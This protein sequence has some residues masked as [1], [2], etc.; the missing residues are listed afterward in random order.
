MKKIALLTDGWRKYVVYAWTEGIMRKIRNENLDMALFQFNSFGNWSRDRDNNAGEYNIFRLPELEEY[1][2]III[3]ANN[4]M[5]YEVLQNLLAIVKKSGKPAVSIG[6][7]FPDLYYVGID[8]R[9]P[10]EEIM[11]HLYNVHNCRRFVFAGGPGDNFENRQRAESYLDCLQKYHLTELNNP[12]LYGDYSFATGVRYM[13]DYIKNNKQLPDVFVCSNDNIATG[14][15]RT[16]E[17]NGYHVPGDFL[18]TGFDNLEKARNYLPQI[19]TVNMDRE[20]IGEQALNIL[21]DIWDGKEVPS[22]RYTDANVI[23]AESCGCPNSGMV[24]YRNYLKSMIDSSCAREVFD[25]EVAIL[26]REVLKETRMHDMFDDIE[27]YMCKKNIDGF[28]IVVDER[29]FD[30]SMNTH[31]PK[32]GYSRPNLKVQLAIV[33]GKSKSFS[34][35]PELIGFMDENL[36]A[37]HYL[38]SPVHFGNEAVGFTV[39]KN[40]EFL[41]EWS[42]LLDIQEGIVSGFKNLFYKK[43]ITNAMKQLE[44]IYNKDQLTGVYNRIALTDIVES[45]FNKERIRGVVWGVVFVDADNFKILN[46]RYGHEYGDKV[47]KKIATTMKE[48]VPEG[49]NVFRFGG[50]EFVALFPNASRGTLKEYRE[51]VVSELKRNDTAIS[52]GCCLTDMNMTLK[53]DDYISAADG[54]MYLEKNA[55]D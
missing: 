16:A 41:Y 14:I 21:M 26:E 2:G 32:E 42:N 7:E 27:R 11:D 12:V 10:I 50:D 24:D 15:C 39:H 35:V 53:L 25:N 29:L 49:G 36:K 18:V 1:D 9:R 17:L 22:H 8:N 33:D 37:S 20:L 19:T 34:S 6:H 45:R 44:D 13:E 38:F 5:D 47:L 4:I 40:P 52:M 55:K 46:D 23:Y 48:Y 43:Q 54:S 28:Y 51:K 31:F 30:P 3:D